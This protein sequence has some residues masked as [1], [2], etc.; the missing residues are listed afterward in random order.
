MSALAASLARPARFLET[1]PAPSSQIQDET[2]IPFA[3][4]RLFYKHAELDEASASVDDLGLAAG[5][6][7]EVFA[8]D[9]NVDVDQLDDDPD[10]GR[11]GPNG[12]GAG[13]KRSRRRREEGFG[14]TGLF[15]FEMALEGVDEADKEAI[16]SALAENAGDDEGDADA[17]A[18]AGSSTAADGRA[19]GVGANGRASASGGRSSSSAAA[20][21]VET[22]EDAVVKCAACT[23]DNFVGLSSCE[24][25]G[26]ELSR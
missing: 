8:V 14:G 2:N 7:L 21:A 24:I 11:A 25:C 3:A 6:T 12:A 4:Q 10:S 16:R 26:T 20:A 23:F 9:T 19:Q 17:G 15:G 18:G 5:D 1:D 22:D 13:G